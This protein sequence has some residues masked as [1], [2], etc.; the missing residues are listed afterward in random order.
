MARPESEELQPED[1]HS[2]AKAD[3][4]F[5]TNPETKEQKELQE[6]T[7][8]IKDEGGYKLYVHAY[9]RRDLN[10]LHITG[11]GGEEVYVRA[12]HNLKVPHEYL[13]DDHFI[14][15]PNKFGGEYMARKD[16]GFDP[17]HFG[18]YRASALAQRRRLLSRE[19]HT[20]TSRPLNEILKTS[21]QKMDAY[22]LNFPIKAEIKDGAGRGVGEWPL[23]T[24]VSDQKL[25]NQTIAFLK[26]N[27]RKTL[28][29]ARQL[30]PNEE[31]PN[32][33]KEILNKANEPEKT[34]FL[35]MDQVIAA[36]QVKEVK[37]R[38]FYSDEYF[39]DD[40]MISRDNRIQPWVYERFGD[41]I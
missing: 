9:N 36:S 25:I 20:L 34:I 2:K 38:D 39:I 18:R 10:D 8:R 31:F 19:V 1:I 16:L 37:M 26:R 27:P 35:D 41:K 5:A 14:P 11:K 4:E 32:V 40:Q 21:K 24:I 15:N 12:I 3:S 13:S 7:R 17:V 29:V 33:N 23:L 30:L 22:F 6:L 28:D